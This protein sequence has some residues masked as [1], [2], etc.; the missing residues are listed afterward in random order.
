MKLAIGTGT[1]RCGSKS[2]RVLALAQPQCGLTHERLRLPWIGGEAHLAEAVAG[3]EGVAAGG[4]PIDALWE[5]EVVRHG[6]WND[7]E[8][9]V[10]DIG[11]WYLPLVPVLVEQYGA[12]V[13][14]LERASEAFVRSVMSG[15]GWLADVP[16]FMSPRVQAA[17]MYWSLTHSLALE[18]E[19]RYPESFRI[20]STW[21]L[22]SQA[23][24]QEM[25]RF[26]GVAEPVVLDQ[27]PAAAENRLA[28]VGP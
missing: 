27:Y 24:Q 17:K 3:W 13:L 22:N 4:R 2:L 18:F 26:I 6:G 1:G 21:D 23:R 10:G 28:E 12:K 19:Q 7:G 5:A 25:M 9:I 20:W 8:K 15:T 16:P 11:P 14:H